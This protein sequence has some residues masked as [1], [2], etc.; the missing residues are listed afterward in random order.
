M[1]FDNGAV[2]DSFT[3]IDNEILTKIYQAKNLTK[4]YKDI[5][6]YLCREVFYQETS[7]VVRTEWWAAAHITA[8][9]V[10]CSERTVRRAYEYLEKRNVLTTRK[11]MKPTLDKNGRE[12]WRNTTL[13]KFNTNTTEWLI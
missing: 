10:G 12:V 5:L 1:K 4:N 3:T 2:I 7:G 9:E 6:L 11:E 13:V 8:D